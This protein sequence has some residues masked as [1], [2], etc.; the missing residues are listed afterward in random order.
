[1]SGVVS[2]ITNL[3]YSRSSS[4]QRVKLSSTFATHISAVQSY[5]IPLRMALHSHTAEACIP[6]LCG[7]RAAEI[8]GANG[9]E[10]LTLCEPDEDLENSIDTG[11][12]NLRMYVN[13][14]L[15]I[16]WQHH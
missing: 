12:E 5:K 2:T 4:S 3:L 1:M 14:L 10:S 6:L 15:V 13:N 9:E 8:F 7:R 11:R 16:E